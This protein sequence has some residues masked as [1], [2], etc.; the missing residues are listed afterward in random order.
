MTQ[1]SPRIVEWYRVDEIRPV[2]AAV[3]KGSLLLMAGC[4]AAGAALSGVVSTDPVLRI[5]AGA[6]GAACT[7]GGPVL[8]MAGFQRI[9]T[10]EAYLA[11]R[12]DGV[13]WHRQRRGE[14]VLWEDVEDARSDVTGTQVI[15]HRRAHAPLCITQRF[16]AIPA[17]DLA[18]RILELRRKAQWNLLHTVR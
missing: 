9:L 7:L 3:A 12:T 1:A 18:R 6:F 10:Q 2:V 13:Y 11:L 4:F 16:D 5:L 17:G 14:L 15:I 8:T